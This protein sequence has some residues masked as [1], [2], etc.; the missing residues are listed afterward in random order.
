MHG[1]A[2]FD[3]TVEELADLRA[4]DAPHCVLDVREPH[5]TAICA[6]PG[7]LLTPLAQVPTQIEALPRDR[8]I[9]VLCHHGVRSAMVVDYLRR[10]GLPNAYN[11]AGGID[12][13]S[14]RID[15]SVPTY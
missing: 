5:E 14:R 13:W 6:L 8:P 2:D 7:A 1:R 3:V 15:P 9:F 10:Q 12:A 11:I 4:A